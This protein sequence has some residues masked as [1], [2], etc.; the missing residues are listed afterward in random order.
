MVRAASRQAHVRK[1]LA[2]RYE[3]LA[4]LHPPA[5]LELFAW[6]VQV[7]PIEAFLTWQPFCDDTV[8]V[9]RREQHRAHAVQP[10]QLAPAAIDMRSMRQP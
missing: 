1:P 9:V 4:E 10:L 7:D 2:R 6:I 8:G 5:L 3:V